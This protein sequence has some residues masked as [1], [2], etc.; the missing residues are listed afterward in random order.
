MRA[1]LIRHPG[2]ACEAVAAIAVQ[3]ERSVAGVLSLRYRVEGVSEGLVVPPAAAPVRTDELWKTTCFEAF[4]RGG[5]RAGYYE[6]NFAPSSQWAAYRFDGYRQGMRP[7]QEIV[8][9]RIRL[10]RAGGRLELDVRLDLGAAD[11]PAAAPWRLG[12]SAVIAETGG[13]TSYWALAHAPKRPD[14]HHADGFVLELP[15]T[16]RP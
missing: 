6:F 12:L 10:R 5:E 3:A 13:R 7:A 8:E 9:P 1:E 15:V 2:L 14:F 11:L 4:V 16:E